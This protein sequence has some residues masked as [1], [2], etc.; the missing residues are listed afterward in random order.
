MTWRRQTVAAQMTTL[1]LALALGACSPVMT[2]R[3]RAAPL[4][5]LEQPDGELCRFELASGATVDMYVTGNSAG[6][7]TGL[8]ARSKRVAVDSRDVRRVGIAFEERDAPA[9]AIKTMVGMSAG[10]A[11]FLLGIV[12]LA[13]AGR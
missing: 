9:S 5:E 2:T 4:S 10:Y 7:L 11:G 8:D 12:V 13:V 1:G 6:R 3:Y